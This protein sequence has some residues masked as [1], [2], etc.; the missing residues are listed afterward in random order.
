MENRDFPGYNPV[1]AESGAKRSEITDGKI[2]TAPAR[3][4]AYA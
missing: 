3:K 2:G 4:L 1:G